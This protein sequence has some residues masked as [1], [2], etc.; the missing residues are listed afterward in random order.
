MKKDCFCPATVPKPTHPRQTGG[1]TP[2]SILSQK[3]AARMACRNVIEM[4]EH[5]GAFKEF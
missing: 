1:A 2:S 3:L 4:H 5:A